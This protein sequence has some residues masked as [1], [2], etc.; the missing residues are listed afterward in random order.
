MAT[1]VS[2]LVTAGLRKGLV[3]GSRLWLVLGLSAGLA[4]LVRRL[5]QRN[6]VS[7]TVELKPGQTLV[8]SHL[9]SAE[10]TPKK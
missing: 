9:K 3:E 8:V 2:R 10:G 7:A 1:L 5:A 6:P 4:K